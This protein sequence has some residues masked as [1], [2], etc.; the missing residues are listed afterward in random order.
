FAL[1]VQPTQTGHTNIEDKAGRSGIISHGVKK[2]TCRDEC[3]HLVT[4]GLNQPCQG[5]PHG[6]IVVD[7]KN[8]G[9]M[10]GH[11][12]REWNSGMVEWW[13]GGKGEIGMMENWNAGILEK[14]ND[15]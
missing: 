7:E 14:W 1:K 13:N 4:G 9:G 10:W 5:A 8:G 2:F 11:G 3:L 15:E 12:T 6:G